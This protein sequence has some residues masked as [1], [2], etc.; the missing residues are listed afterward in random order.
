M[1]IVRNNFCISEVLPPREILQ[2]KLVRKY[3]YIMC[4]YFFVYICLFLFYFDNNAIACNLLVEA[5]IFY[6]FWHIT[7]SRVPINKVIRY[8]FIITPLFCV[9]VIFYFKSQPLISCLWLIPYSYAAY[10]YLNSRQLIYHLG[11]SFFLILVAQILP[12][13]F[14]WGIPTYLAEKTAVVATVEILGNIAL[15]IML[16]AY[17]DEISKIQTSGENKKLVLATEKNDEDA[18]SNALFIKIQDEMVHGLLFKDPEFSISTLSTI[19]KMSNNYISKAVRHN[20]YSNFSDY[21]NFHRISYVKQLIEKSD[22]TTLTLMYVYT[23][24]GFSNQSTFNRVFKK[25]EGITP[26]EYIQKSIPGKQTDSAN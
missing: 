5:V 15:T 21:L 4:I 12:F 9:P 6:G 11:Y 19:V 20:G 3:V 24:A 25:I 18:K 1:S 14:S 26:S 23:E 2:K 17:S 7:Q 13:I 8:Y 16:V 10:L 22:L